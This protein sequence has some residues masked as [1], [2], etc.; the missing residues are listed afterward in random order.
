[1]K[2]SDVFGVRASVNTYSYIDRGN[3]DEQIKKISEREMH[4]ALKGE[5]KAGKSWLR[6]KAFPNSTVVQC[7]LGFQPLDI[8]RSILSALNIDI[9][10]SK[11]ASAGGRIEFSGSAEAG[12]KLIAKAA[13]EVNGE[14]AI[15]RAV[16]KKPVGKDEC[17]LEFIC[18]LIKCSD[19]KVIIEDFHYLKDDVQR[20]LAHDLKAFWDYQT[21]VVIIGVW[22]RRNYLIHLNPDLAGRITEVSVS[23][24][25]DDLLK[26]IE[27]GSAHL[28]VDID[29]LIK[30]RLITDC[31]GNVG[32][33]QALT[34]ETLDQSNIDGRHAEK[35][36]CTRIDAYES[37]A[38]NYAE[39]LEAVYLEFSRRVSAGIRKRQ[40]ST[41]IYAHAMLA[42]FESPD[43]E[44][45]RGVPFQT[46]YNRAHQRQS[47]VQQGN[48]KSILKNI[49]K[50]QVD[51]RGK[52]LVLTFAEQANSVAVVDRSV[53]FFRKYSTVVWPWEE[54][55]QELGDT[56]LEGEE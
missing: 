14:G 55:T 11:N 12:W 10:I 20:A 44:L 24:T 39:Q 19:T 35:Q 36:F 51:D 3:L 18:R 48:L 46:I 49:D 28:N 9:T 6:Q 27:Q 31:Y 43:E 40:G 8:Y 47:R 15:E 53:L 17:D 50:L 13:A 22:V 29:K 34:L 33:L 42:C 41:N 2:A 16:E 7:R 26:V 37:A 5:S 56:E 45:I 32:L 25:N 23:W 1:M 52:G 54:I 38:M 30:D 21:F 4:I